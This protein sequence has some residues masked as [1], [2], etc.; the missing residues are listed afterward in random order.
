M[1]RREAGWPGPTP[2]AGN[3]CS[4]LT[5]LQPRRL[6]AVWATVIRRADPP[7]LFV[8]LVDHRDGS[9]RDESLRPRSCCAAP[10]LG[11]G[12]WPASLPAA[13]RARCHKS[14]KCCRRRRRSGWA[15][16][17]RRDSVAT[18]RAR[19]GSERR[20][21]GFVPS[22]RFRLLPNRCFTGARIAQAAADIVST[23]A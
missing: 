22:G 23:A 15:D 19:S 7:E 14:V 10:R 8:N 5:L 9:R 12:P 17:E 21:R 20:R 6:R 11:P 18:K 1:C 16:L 13:R 3:A 4:A 2:L